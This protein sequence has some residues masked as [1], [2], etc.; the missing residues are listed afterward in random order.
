MMG[1]EQGV[2]K[3]TCRSMEM[4]I[5]THAGGCRLSVA[6]GKSSLAASPGLC[7]FLHAPEGS[8]RLPLLRPEAT[9]LPLE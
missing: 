9:A 2:A 6:A 4:P 5:T 1:K 7:L 3:E 8:Y